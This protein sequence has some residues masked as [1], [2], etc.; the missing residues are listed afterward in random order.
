MQEKQDLEQDI[1]HFYHVKQ[2]KQDCMTTN[3]LQILFQMKNS[4]SIFDVAKM[5]N[6]YKGQPIICLGRSPKWFLNTSLWMKDGIDGYDFVAFSKY[7]YRPDPIDGVKLIPS[8]APTEK[9]IKS[10]RKYLDRIQADP[11][12]IVAF[13]E[14]TGKKTI[15]TDFIAT[16]KGAASFLD[17]MGHYAQDEGILEKFAKSIEIVGIGSMD[18][19]ESLNPYL[20]EFSEPSVPLPPILQNMEEILNN[21]STISRISKCS[22]IC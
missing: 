21:T 7:W 13:H 3:T 14:A 22:K 5:Y 16:G 1:K 6:K 2:T 4:R 18:Y 19:L 8:M 20:E 12:S 11:K 15:L 17:I 9:E 10:Y